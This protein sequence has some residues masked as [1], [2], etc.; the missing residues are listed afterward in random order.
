MNNGLG[1]K[2]NELAGAATEQGKESREVRLT[3]YQIGRVLKK[4]GLFQLSDRSANIVISYLAQL[5]VEFKHRLVANVAEHRLVFKYLDHFLMKHKTCYPEAKSPCEF[6]PV[7][8]ELVGN[9]DKSPLAAMLAVSNSRNDF[10]DENWRLFQ[11]YGAVASISLLANYIKFVTVKNE[12]ILM[13]A[14]AAG[15]RR[16][17]LSQSRTDYALMLPDLEL[18]GNLKSFVTSWESFNEKVNARE[19]SPVKKALSETIAYQR[20][21]PVQALFIKFWSN[22]SSQPNRD[23]VVG[24]V[25]TSA[26]RYSHN[27][28]RPARLR[29]PISRK[30]SSKRDG[31]E[32]A[33]E[34][35]L[36]TEIIQSKPKLSGTLKAN[37]FARKKR[38]GAVISRIIRA[39]LGLATVPQLLSFQHMKL[40]IG[41]LELHD[42]SS[43]HFHV[44][45]WIFLIIYLSQ[46]RDTLAK[47]LII[48]KHEVDDLQVSLSSVALIYKLQ[49]NLASH[50]KVQRLGL[51]EERMNEIRI[52][53]PSLF[54][55]ND[56]LKHTIN[57][58]PSE[59]RIS[60][61]LQ[62]ICAACK[63]S[64]VSINQ[65]A[66]WQFLHL[67]RVWKER[68]EAAAVTGLQ[69]DN[70]TPL[71]YC[72]INTARAQQ[73]H[74]QFWSEVS[75][76]CEQWR[77]SQDFESLY[78]HVGEGDCYG[79]T[80]RLKTQKLTLF[81]QYF[82][83]FIEELAQTIE[84][85][86]SSS[87]TSA[88]D[89]NQHYKELHNAYTVYVV[90]VVKLA[91][92][93]RPVRDLFSSLADFDFVNCRIYINDKQRRE[94]MARIVPMCPLLKEQLIEYTKYLTAILVEPAGHPEILRHRIELIVRSEAQPFQI[95]SDSGLE[96][97]TPSFLEDFLSNSFPVPL[98]FSRHLIRT[99]MYQDETLNSVII[100]DFMAHD[101]EGQMSQ[102]L[103]STYTYRDEK[104]L[105]QTIQR[106]LEAM[107]TKVSNCPLPL[108]DH[109]RFNAYTSLPD[110]IKQRVVT[111]FEK[112]TERAKRL[113]KI[114]QRREQIERNVQR[115][116]SSSYPDLLSGSGSEQQ[117]NVYVQ[118]VSEHLRGKYQSPDDYYVAV[119]Y[120]EN[121]CDHVNST[122]SKSITLPTVTVKVT[123]EP[124][125][126]NALSV[127]LAQRAAILMRLI[128]E[129]NCSLEEMTDIDLRCLL[130]FSIALH[131]G[132]N[133]GHWLQ[134]LFSQSYEH[135]QIKSAALD[136]TPLLWVCLSNSESSVVNSYD[137]HGRAVHAEYIFLNGLQTGLV[138]EL[139][140]RKSIAC[141]K[142]LA[143]IPKLLKK[144][145][146]LQS[147]S[148]VFVAEEQKF[149]GVTSLLKFAVDAAATSCRDYSFALRHTANSTVETYSL[150]SQS[151]E[152]MVNPT[153][154]QV[155]VPPSIE[156]LDV[157]G[158]S[159]VHVN[160]SE[161]S[162]RTR[163]KKAL[164]LDSLN[165]YNRLS[166]VLSKKENLSRPRVL[167]ELR[168]I[169]DEYSHYDA[170]VYLVN[171][172]IS[173]IKFRNN[174]ISTCRRYH[175]AI[176]LNWLMATVTIDDL[177]ELTAGDLQ[178]LYRQAIEYTQSESED[179]TELS[180]G[181][182]ELPGKP[183]IPKGLTQEARAKERERH[184]ERYFEQ[185][186]REKSY[187]SYHYLCD[188]FERFH[189]FLV[190]NY[191][192]P[193]LEQPI[194][195]RISHRKEY[196]RTGYIPN[197]LYQA[198][199]A[200]L[201]D[202]KGCDD[203][204][205]F[206]IQII[207]I[208]AYRTGMRMNEILTLTLRDVTTAHEWWLRVRNNPFGRL[209]SLS[210]S[211][212]IPLFALLDNDEISL[213]NQWYQR[214]LARSKKVTELLFCDA[215]SP[216]QVWPEWLIRQSVVAW[217]RA[218]SGQNKLTFHDFRHTALS[219]LQ[220]LIEGEE[221][222]FCY[223]SGHER[224]T[225]E[226]IIEH[227]FGGSMVR[228]DHYYALAILA[229]H[230]SP[231]VT[232]KN[233]LHFSSL[234]RHIK[235]S[236]S[237]WH[238][239]RA[240][241]RM[242]TRLAEAQLARLCLPNPKPLSSVR[243]R[244]RSNSDF[245]DGQSLLRHL[246]R[247]NKKDIV[248]VKQ[249]QTRVIEFASE[250]LLLRPSASDVHDILQAV[251]AGKS[252]HEI[253]ELYQVNSNI[254][255]CYRDQ[256]R[257]LLKYRTRVKNRR[258]ISQLDEKNDVYLP[259]KPFTIA[260]RDLA[261]RIINK[262]LDFKDEQQ[263][264]VI[265]EIAEFFIENIHPGEAGIR[266]RNGDRLN[267]FVESLRPF[268]SLKSWY[269][270]LVTQRAQRK[271]ALSFMEELCITTKRPVVKIKQR[272]RAEYYL[273]LKH[274]SSDD[275]K[276]NALYQATSLLKY[277]FSMV[278]IMIRAEAEAYSETHGSK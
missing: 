274:P 26:M 137:K 4:L 40:L 169:A 73:R 111:E 142:T 181:A 72:T 241:V 28:E 17:R 27:D 132:Q 64:R 101:I 150:P 24:G 94:G 32:V 39:E 112:T 238:F 109:I 151:F 61:R 221:D 275:R 12:S 246:A 110:Y 149:V 77:L 102:G 107:K 50:L 179:D 52:L 184:Q 106:F 261:R 212:D 81:L 259:R 208:L 49:R 251:V 182:Q 262:M 114:E 79:S 134:F 7:H 71:Y 187:K 3:E 127:N 43:K 67:S 190:I 265:L 30:K 171:W 100:D 183:R 141:E 210:S 166:K 250:T 224:S 15:L 93:I 1:D 216:R 123:R 160:K 47:A 193:R 277:V 174:S 230:T 209:K 124:A 152:Y 168:Q 167:K 153:L 9:L 267:W 253:S 33:V 225:A 92:G 202:T 270:Y 68:C 14:V 131:S 46:T 244:P 200:K 21:G 192:L 88:E 29:P 213:F 165:L 223:L 2:L 117:L 148:E 96:P 86:S 95:F 201:P 257:A 59:K 245:V 271:E 140:K 57:S 87:Q 126:R 58:I 36:N 118:K 194:K 206:A 154:N 22:T 155:V 120:F 273:R 163:I 220:I 16:I 268:I 135:A 13:P 84:G 56:V 176:S 74:L 83:N 125:T 272:G 269:I 240:Q 65:L 186:E 129:L 25:R 144:S 205:K 23:R 243:E 136:N 82:Y 264:K 227:V 31:E 263:R 156:R 20:S 226:R 44:D 247:A 237:D 147:L 199:L 242:Y 63:I 185:I 234:L 54:W 218:L 99:W 276:Q 119:K 103:Y 260:E 157:K 66:S 75:Q 37:N 248:A 55:R 161:K 35:K 85:M 196:V 113:K 97:I 122:Y 69:P 175:S 138:L 266:F 180:V 278:S 228:I 130:V 78:R 18:E 11:Y 143:D 203:D 211:R 159:R 239:S 108:P 207:T 10:S 116:I 42:E 89:L 254:I 6:E 195:S 105:N 252:N 191:Q 115:F 173:H 172:F 189:E 214:R 231:S 197:K 51:L 41:A 204:T 232:F 256:A 80:L 60:A 91:T 145:N 62:D 258:L 222:L 121:V 177:S 158:D 38:A 70:W 170:I 34:E 235:L 255:Q 188:C 48:R 128:D 219:N 162:S 215:D 8:K 217:L 178:E 146:V 53:L 5:H 249:R 139:K 104:Q 98:N 133:S 233:Y 90:L 198:V 164:G 19:K 236:T 76:E 229:G 45:A